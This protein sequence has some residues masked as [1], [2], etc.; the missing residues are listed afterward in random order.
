MIWVYIYGQY[1][2]VSVLTDICFNL[3]LGYTA[4]EARIGLR[5]SSNNIDQAITYIIERRESRKKARK[6]GKA[7]RNIK[8]SLAK[9]TNTKWVNPRNLHILHEMGFEKD[10]S[11]VALQKCD[12]DLN[13]AVSYY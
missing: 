4:A 10:I 5:A 2:F 7:E 3:K 9:T 12:N 13:Q 11:A 8:S 1:R 6:I